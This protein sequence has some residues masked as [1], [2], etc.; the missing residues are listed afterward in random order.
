MTAL[1]L[2]I[3]TGMILLILFLI[4]GLQ[5]PAKADTDTAAHAAVGQ[6]VHLAGSS[7]VRGDRL[8]DDAEYRGLRSNPALYPVATKLRKDRRELA[9]LWINLL[10]TDLQTLW[11]FRRFVIQRGAPTKVSEEWA[12]LRSFL[13]ALIFLNLL[14][15]SIST[16][17]PF[18]FSR[19]SRNAHRSVD[20]M[21]DAAAKLLAR[22]PA[23]GW[24]DLERA[25]TSTAA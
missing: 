23:A 10:L 12:I 25:W 21:S 19:L 4:L 22:L 1:V 6:M 20:M 13:M 8:L 24:P 2:A 16:M 11:H 3:A 9:L 17:G 15:L 5:G 18:A 7:F 14:K